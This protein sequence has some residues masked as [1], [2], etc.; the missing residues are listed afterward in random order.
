MNKKGFTLVELLAVIAVLGIIISVATISAI[1]IIDKSRKNTAKE[2]V[3][4]LKDVAITYCIEDDDRW[5]GNTCTVSVATL[6]SRGEFEDTKKRCITTA[7][8]VVSVA[9]VTSTSDKEDYVASISGYSSA[10]EYKV[11]NNQ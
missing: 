9:K 7:N 3:A 5:S 6:I 10:D 2:N 1:S 4:N 8:I 11:C